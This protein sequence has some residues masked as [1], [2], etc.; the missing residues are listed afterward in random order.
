MSSARIRADSVLPRELEFRS[1]HEIRSRCPLRLPRAAIDP[2]DQACRVC[3][4]TLSG[5]VYPALAQFSP[6][7]Q[8]PA[9][10]APSFVGVTDKDP[11]VVHFWGL[12]APGSA[13]TGVAAADL[14]DSSV[15]CVTAAN[16]CTGVKTLSNGQLDIAVGLYCN[17]ASQTVTTWASTNCTFAGASCRIMKLY[18]PIGSASATPASY[19]VAPYFILSGVN[20]KPT[21]ACVSA[22]STLIT[23]T[24][25]SIGGPFSVG[26]TFERNGT[27]TTFQEYVGGTLSWIALGGWGAANA[28]WAQGGSMTGF[29]IT[30]VT[31]GS[32]TTDFSKF[33]RALLTIPHGF[34]HIGC[35]C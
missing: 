34:R 5:M 31:D 23:A 12:V 16:I 4:G 30:G 26:V 27:F 9:A 6:M 35:V 13:H 18:D 19:T 1:R 7:V 25:T 28:M 2:R 15:S 20:S 22:N 3:G 10:S 17:S 14:C 24:I 33:H 29:E 8:G 11:N 32:G 21:G